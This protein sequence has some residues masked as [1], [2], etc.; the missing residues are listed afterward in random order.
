MSSNEDCVSK[1]IMMLSKF[2][3]KPSS[4]TCVNYREEQQETE[5]NWRAKMI[6]WS[7]QRDSTGFV[8]SLGWPLL[9]W[10]SMDIILFSNRL[11]RYKD[12]LKFIL[13]FQESW[14]R[15]DV[16]G[17]MSVELGA[18]WSTHT[19]STLTYVI[20]TIVTPS[21]KQDKANLNFGFWSLFVGQWTNAVEFEN[22]DTEKLYHCEL[23]N[24]QQW[25][26]RLLVVC[27]Y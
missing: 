24:K 7:Q 23:D 4:G 20:V 11:I 5:S 2:D 9:T 14:V 13:K 25:W 17:W 22:N 15:S 21:L 3:G 1:G 18:K 16:G 27:I 6:S 10:A 26:T 8:H 12:S 19:T